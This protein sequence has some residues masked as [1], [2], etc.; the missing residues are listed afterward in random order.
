MGLGVNAIIFFPRHCCYNGIYAG[1]FVLRNSVK[2]SLS[3]AHK[4]YGGDS[5]C[6]IGLLIPI[7]CCQ[8]VCIMD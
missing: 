1:V 7:V 2:P 4:W 6:S 8:L 3:T 5:L